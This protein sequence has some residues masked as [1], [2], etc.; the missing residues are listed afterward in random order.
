MASPEH[1]CNTFCLRSII[2]SLAGDI[3]EVLAAASG[4][5]QLKT[6]DLTK[7]AFVGTLPGISFPTLETLRLAD[8]NIEVWLLTIGEVSP[9]HATACIHLRP[10]WNCTSVTLLCSHAT[11]FS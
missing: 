4:L 11:G 9:D 1:N 2:S 5:K 3:A 7:Q 8:N 6:L 10:R